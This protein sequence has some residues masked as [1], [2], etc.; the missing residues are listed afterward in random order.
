MVDESIGKIVNATLQKGGATIVSADHG[1]IE[2]LT[3]IKTGEV[4]TEHST[5]P[6]P[7]IFASSGV[8]ARELHFGILA[9]IAP[10]MLDLMGIE[11]PDQMTG[12]SLLEK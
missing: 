10:T 4:D 6:V 11:Q 2:E 9:D 1:N 5:N 8:E 3:N 12:K 7:F